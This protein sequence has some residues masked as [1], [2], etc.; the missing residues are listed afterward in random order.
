MR[1]SMGSSFSWDGTLSS[2]EFHVAAIALSERW[3]EI[4]PTSPPW[5]WIPSPRYP[6][7]APK[8]ADGY[9][10]L[11]SV[12]HLN[13]KEEHYSEGSCIGEEEPLDDATLV[14]SYNQESHVYDFHILYSASYRVPVL[15]FRGYRCDGQPMVLE[16]IENDLPSI[17]SK[18]MKEFKWAFITQE[19][20]P[21]LNQPWFT[22]HP[23]GTSDWMKLLFDG[24]T[25]LNGDAVIQK[26]LSSWL[27]VVGQVIGL[28]TPLE[29][30]SL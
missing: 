25:P 7:G 16:D 1:N 10:S 28:R 23:C 8:K 9:L 3:R 4:N 27:S 19:E 18:Q 21:Y 5:T 14:Q 11:E 2:D 30:L 17:S 20:H 26:Y 6:W 15:Y 22:L 24:G 29:M 12:Y 13:P